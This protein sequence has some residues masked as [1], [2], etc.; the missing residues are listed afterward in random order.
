MITIPT[1]KPHNY[2]DF[3][4][5]PDKVIP[6]KDNLVKGSEVKFNIFDGWVDY[7]IYKDLNELEPNIISKYDE[8]G[9]I[10]LYKPN[11]I[12]S[13]KWGMMNYKVIGATKKK[14]DKRTL[15]IVE[16]IHPKAIFKVIYLE[17]KDDKAFDCGHVYNPTLDN[18]KDTDINDEYK[19]YRNSKWIK[20]D[21]N[22]FMNLTPKVYKTSI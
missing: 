20:L 13:D 15:L 18:W 9:I 8:K 16:D 7:P 4:G 12:H 3:N 21:P 22:D 10:Y 14:K 5:T 17:I 2:Y 11:H 19:G 6:R 1:T